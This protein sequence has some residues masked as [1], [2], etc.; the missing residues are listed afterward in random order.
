MSVSVSFALVFVLLRGSSG[1]SSVCFAREGRWS[2]D[3][4]IAHISRR[5]A[6]DLLLCA[7]E[8]HGM[9]VGEFACI[10]DGSA[11][12]AWLDVEYRRTVAYDYARLRV[13]G[14]GWGG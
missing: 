14:G 4:V 11:W 2:R 3:Y 7:S 9:R 12:S 8:M 10:G 1:R 13:R 6:L 5:F